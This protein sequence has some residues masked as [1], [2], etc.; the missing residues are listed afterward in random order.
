MPGSIV[1]GPAVASI[2]QL[3][4]N[5]NISGVVIR[6]NSPG[7]SATASE[8]IMRALEQLAQAKPVVFSMGETAASGGYYIT[9][10]GR[11]ILAEA[12]TISGSIGVFGMKLN[13]GPLMRRI[14]IHQELVALDEESGLDAFD[15]GLSERDRDTLQRHVDELYDRFLGYVAKSR[16]L[17]R[18]EVEA[19]A[20]GRVWSGRQAVENKLVDRIGGLQDAIAMVAAEAALEPDKCEVVHLPRPRSFM[21]NI[22]AQ[23]V[24]MRVLASKLAGGLPGALLQRAGGLRGAAA[25]LFDAV[26]AGRPPRI[27]ALPALDFVLR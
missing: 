8:A 14:G 9:C 3:A 18:A 23:L 20:G 6:I 16:G 21:D 5:E 17:P 13:L 26:A 15:R 1:S 7:G 19:I 12:G 2:R 10:I 27:W 22:A 11:P 24:E 25:V 4:D